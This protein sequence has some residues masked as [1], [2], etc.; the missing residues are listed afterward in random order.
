MIEGNDS[1]P[2]PIASQEPEDKKILGNGLPKYYLN[3][4]NSVSYKRF[5]LNVTMRGAFAFQILNMTKMFYAVP[6]SLTRGNVMKCTYDNI[7]GKVPLND[8]QELQ[9]VSYFIEN[10]DYWKIDNITLGYTFN[11]R[12]GPVKYLRIYASGSNMFTFTGYSGI[13]P[14]VNSVGLYPGNDNRDRY[15]STRTYTLGFSV[16]F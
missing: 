2:K 1:N 10:G 13:D 8:Y 12:N 6:V 11:L 7:Y 16:K 9:Y 5:D 4:N 14:E 15:P 3:W